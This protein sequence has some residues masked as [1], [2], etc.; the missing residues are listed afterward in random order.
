MSNNTKTFILA[1]IGL[2][3]FASLYIVHRCE[4]KRLEGLKKSDTVYSEKI[5]TLWKTDTFKITEFI[6]KNIIKTK[7]DTIVKKDGDTLHL[8]TESKEFNKTL[9]KGKDTADVKI[10]TSGINTQLDSLKMRLK[11]HN[12]VITKTIEITK[13]KPKTFWNRFHIGLQV[14]YGIGLRSKQFEP[15]AGVGVSFDF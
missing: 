13:E 6:P 8:I 15:Y 5:D 10:Y 7:V 9:V 4:I 1:F 14:G 3:L 2:F 12:E 11:T